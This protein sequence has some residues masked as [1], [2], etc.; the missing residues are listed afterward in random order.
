M[1]LPVTL[2][3]ASFSYVDAFISLHPERFATTIVTGGRAGGRLRSRERKRLA[4]RPPAP[5]P[6]APLA[7]PPAPRPRRALPRRRQARKDT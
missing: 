3:H 5:P 1:H 2:M 7:R 4:A 6:R